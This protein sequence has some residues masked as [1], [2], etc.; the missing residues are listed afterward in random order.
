MMS[1]RIRDSVL[2]GFCLLVVSGLLLGTVGCSSFSGIRSRLGAN[3][4]SRTFVITNEWAR[5]TPKKEFLG[6]RRMNRMSPLVSDSM[7]IEGNAIDSMI[8]YNRKDGSEIWRIPL[9][10]GVEGGAQIVGDRLYFG[11]SDGQF[12]CV[13]TTTGE[14]L[15]TFEVRAETLAQPTVDNGI[16]Y[17]ESGADVVYALNATDGKQ[18]WTYNRQLTGNLS[19]RATTRPIVAGDNVLV[20]FSDGF[21]V[22]L[23]KRDGG[24]IWERKLGRSS[25]FKDVD[26][27]PV[28]EGKEVYVSSFDA[29][30]YSLNVETGEV[31]W[32]LDD[33]AYV[34]VTMGRGRFSDRLFYS[35]A[36]GK[37]VAVDKR[38]GRS[39]SSFSVKNGIPTQ[40]VLYKG[41]L[42]YGESDGALVVADAEKGQV[43]S[44][45]EPG[46]GV[47]S[48]PTVIEA[49]G[50]A[51]FISNSANLYALKMGYR[52]PVDL[53]P[54]QMPPVAQK[55]M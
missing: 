30:L 40:V 14:I 16:V 10:N 48:K 53:M 21:L 25:R 41:F 11:S 13:K 47:V 6:F 34:P 8:A 28:V 49:T 1:L 26:A 50:E 27:T 37:I 15:W 36:N 33:G 24:L 29:A 5:I 44:R 54:W 9:T 2:V 31:N 42:V 18:L 4:Q 51:F 46:H 52:S 38:S 35:T 45:F 17:F 43:I 55:A 20:G 39:L 3:Q 32:S 12:Y 19:I 7:V 22:S 23:K